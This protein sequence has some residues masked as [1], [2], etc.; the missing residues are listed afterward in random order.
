MLS[1]AVSTIIGSSFM[2]Q[3]FWDVFYLPGFFLATSCTWILSSSAK[4]GGSGGGKSDDRQY[5]G[6]SL[7][8]LHFS[9]NVLSNYSFCEHR[10]VL[11]MLYFILPDQSSTQ[12]KSIMD[13]V[14]MP[15]AENELPGWSG[16]N[17]ARPSLVFYLHD[18]LSALLS[19]RRTGPGGVLSVRVVSNVVVEVNSQNGRK[20]Q[21]HP[22]MCLLISYNCSLDRTTKESGF[23]TLIIYLIDVILKIPL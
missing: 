18:H 20:R 10:F 15:W 8:K 22:V 11:Q 6:L 16:S 4:Q 17:Q 13:A 7:A 14:L 23:S 9:I 2:Q 3:H 21:Q 19:E 12:R 1:N 5:F